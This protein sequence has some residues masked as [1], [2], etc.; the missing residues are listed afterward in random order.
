[1]PYVCPPP[2][3]ES[4]RVNVGERVA[5]TRVQVVLYRPTSPSIRY[6]IA[7]TSTSSDH[8]AVKKPGCYNGTGRGASLSSL[9]PP[10][11][12]ACFAR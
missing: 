3:L 6:K 4:V 1:M 12:L 5:G 11:R 2:L 10:G 7:D 9:Y 8:G